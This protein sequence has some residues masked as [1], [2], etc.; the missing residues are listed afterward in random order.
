MFGNITSID[1]RLFRTFFIF[2]VFAAARHIYGRA[3]VGATLVPYG[4]IHKRFALAFAAKS[5]GKAAIFCLALHGV[6]SLS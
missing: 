6:E 1:D 3:R 5:V 2:V 4:V